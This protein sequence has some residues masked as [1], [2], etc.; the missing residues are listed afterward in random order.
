MHVT[1]KGNNLHHND[2]SL[3]WSKERQNYLKRHMDENGTL[4]DHFDEDE[5]CCKVNSE[6]KK[7]RRQIPEG[8]RIGFLEI[9][10]ESDYVEDKSV[11]FSS[12]K[13]GLGMLEMGRYGPH[14]R[15]DVKDN[16]HYDFKNFIF[17]FEPSEWA[18]GIDEQRIG[19]DQVIDIT[20]DATGEI[21]STARQSTPIYVN[22]GELIHPII[23]SIES[24]ALCTESR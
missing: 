16:L 24:F 12:E 15:N 13:K 14:R 4:L 5:I 9:H 20:D 6:V 22:E 8:E 19:R 18:Y 10:S 2:N 11:V 23:Y 17:D 3:Y 21:H 7:I 1:L